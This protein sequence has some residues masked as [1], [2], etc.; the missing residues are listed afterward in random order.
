MKDVKLLYTNN[1]NCKYL[2]L[3]ILSTII[4]LKLI[5]WMVQLSIVGLRVYYTWI[6]RT[7]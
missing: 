1:D 5:R 3:Y 7:S 4:L 2:I 6:A